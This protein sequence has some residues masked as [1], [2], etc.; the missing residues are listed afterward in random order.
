[1]FFEFLQDF[2]YIFGC[3]YG[4]CIYFY[5][6]YVLMD[7]FLE[8]YEVFL[9]VSFYGLC[10]E[11]YYVWFKY[12]YLSFFSCPFAWNAFFHP[13]ALSLCMSF[14]LRWVSCR[15]HMCRSCFLIHLAT[16]C[17]LIG[18]FNPV[19]FKVII[20]RYLL[21][22]ILVPSHLCSFLSLS[23]SHSLPSFS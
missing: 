9:C 8:Y 21:I 2:S 14:V 3:S 6:V 19:M 22:A 12:C 23:L 11:V 20:E 17:L 15:Q 10:F 13:F 16:L 18:A 5:N 4:G 1:M 7:S